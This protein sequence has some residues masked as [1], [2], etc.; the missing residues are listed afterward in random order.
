MDRDVGGMAEAELSKWAHQVKITPNKS[1][2]DRE[3]WDYLLQFPFPETEKGITLDTRP[4]RIECLVQV[5]GLETVQTRKSIKLS[6][7]ERLVRSPL[8]AFFLIID[9]GTQDNPNNAYL[10]HVGE[11][12]INK[13]LHRLRELSSEDPESLNKKYLDLTWN[14]SSRLA[15]LNGVG[16]KNAIEVHIGDSM[17]EYQLRKI[18]IRETAGDPIPAQMHISTAFETGEELWTKLVDFAIGIREEI[19][20]SSM[21]LE[22]DVRFNIPARCSH[23][24]SEGIL[25]VTGR[26]TVASNLILRN[27]TNT[28]RSVFP[29]Q[30]YTP[31]WLFA[32]TPIP[33]QYVKERVNFEI[34]DIIIH[35][36]S[37]EALVNLHF[38]QAK[39][40]QS[41]REH[42]NLWRVVSILQ[43]TQTDDCI[44]EVQDGKDNVLESG[45][46][47]KLALPPPD[48]RLLKVARAVDNLWFLAR[49][50]DI[51]PDTK[52]MLSHI[53]QQQ[54]VTEQLRQ[55]CDINYPIDCITGEIDEVDNDAIS[56]FEAAI[57]FLRK[58]AFNT[59]SI[60]VGVAL[61]GP[62]TKMTD[63]S[64]GRSPFK[65]EKPRRILLR[66]YVVQNDDE[67]GKILQE[68]LLEELSDELQNRGCEVIHLM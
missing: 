28:L 9:F 5:K 1:V 15:T 32:G 3:A 41:L 8:P 20:T 62:L 27:K 57:P 33:E 56:E 29:A 4:S 55:L 43:E 65:I 53:V 2:F 52:M 30:L 46:L 26:P 19:S 48:E 38:S 42:A 18:E 50:F 39:E 54:L 35:P 21:M 16:L 60:I 22:E 36:K 59:I 51:S 12:W 7:W 34:G 13:V 25:R 11:M 64:T 6:N 45:K 63:E 67:E 44:I 66:H 49:H 14:Q 68:R 37:K 47:P 61:A 23:Y 24:D 40:F 10:V 31:Y 58:V 17:K